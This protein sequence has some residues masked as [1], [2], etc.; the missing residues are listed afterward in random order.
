MSLW[1]VK[2]T[3]TF[4]ISFK[5]YKNNHAITDSAVSSRSPSTCFQHRKLFSSTIFLTTGLAMFILYKVTPA[6]VRVSAMILFSS[7]WGHIFLSVW[8]LTSAF[9]AISVKG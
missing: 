8:K 1:E 7:S 2:R 5:K 4:L 3:E 6:S 9:F